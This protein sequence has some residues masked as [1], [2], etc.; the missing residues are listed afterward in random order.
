MSPTILR[1]T[2]IGDLIGMV[3]DTRCGGPYFVQV[4]C[5]REDGHTVLDYT[6]QWGSQ[7]EAY[8]D[9]EA[10][11]SATDNGHEKLHP[12]S[13]GPPTEDREDDQMK[14]GWEDRLMAEE[15]EFNNS[16]A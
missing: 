3:M 11:I 7:V 10:W 6:M 13:Y 2:T 12:F 8:A 5:T 16:D 1:I 15:H 9:W 14:E 4:Y